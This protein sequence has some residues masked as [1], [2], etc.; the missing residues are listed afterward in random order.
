MLPCFLTKSALVG[1]SAMQI[2]EGL[3]RLHPAVML[4]TVVSLRFTYSAY[5]GCSRLNCVLLQWQLSPSRLTAA[6][7]L[8]PWGQG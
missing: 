1:A 7:K 3:L 4:K 8:R 5:P 2:L 6:G